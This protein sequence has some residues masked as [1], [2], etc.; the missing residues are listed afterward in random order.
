VKLRSRFRAVHRFKHLARGACGQHIS[1]GLRHPL[2]DRRHLCRRLALR[3]DHF[4]HSGAQ[5]AVMVELGKAKILEGQIAQAL[6][7]FRHAG[8]PGT[9][10][11]QQRFN[12]QSIH[13]CLFSTCFSVAARSVSA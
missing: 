11:V 13:Q 3:E 12:L 5:R 9:H 8:R 10:F 6:Q 4:G 7:R 1:A 2:E